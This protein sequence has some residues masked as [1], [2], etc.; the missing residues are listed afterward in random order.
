[1][2]K[3]CTPEDKDINYSLSHMQLYSSQFLDKK[4]IPRCT[5]PKPIIA[6]RV[7]K[8]GGVER[9]AIITHKDGVVRMYKVQCKM[10]LMK[11]TD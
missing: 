4:V 9:N 5:P 6:N 3:R 7:I 1:M 10:Q 11:E 2:F 8:E